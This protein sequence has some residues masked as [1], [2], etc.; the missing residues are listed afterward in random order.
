MQAAVVVEEIL[1]RL[2]VALVVADK[3]LV[4]QAVK[5]LS[6]VLPTQVQVVEQVDKALTLLLTV[7]QELLLFVI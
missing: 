6:L 5:T 3:A 7:A 4:T 2:L 1:L